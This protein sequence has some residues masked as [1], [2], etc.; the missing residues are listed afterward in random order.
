MNKR[1]D[2]ILPT[3]CMPSTPRK[4]RP[5]VKRV[6]E[7]I[8]DRRKRPMKDIAACDEVTS[9]IVDDLRSANGLEPAD[10]MKAIITK[11]NAEKYQDMHFHS[12]QTS[13]KEVGYLKQISHGLG[14]VKKDLGVLDEVRREFAFRYATEHRKGKEWCEIFKISR[15]TLRN[16]LAREDVAQYIAKIRRDRNSLMSERLLSLE[17]KAYAKLDSLLDLDI[18][19]VDNAQIVQ[20]SIRDVLSMMGADINGKGSA[21]KGPA[22][23]IYNN[24]TQ[25]QTNITTDPSELKSEI[26]DLHKQLAELDILDGAYEEIK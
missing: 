21:N 14:G 15:Y 19:D 17:K 7:A 23:Q 3:N 11:E 8:N 9:Q 5:K 6:S 24:Q 13:N 10:D 16:W 22:V 4:K 18:A 20:T 26:Q 2:T 12:S 25:G 1:L